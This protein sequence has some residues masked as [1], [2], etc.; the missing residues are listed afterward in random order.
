MGKL[1]HEDLE[2]EASLGYIVGFYVA[3]KQK[4]KKKRLFASFPDLQIRKLRPGKAK[5]SYRNH[6]GR[7]RHFQC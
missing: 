3:K 5:W 1:R 4:N 2:F 7:I 6:K